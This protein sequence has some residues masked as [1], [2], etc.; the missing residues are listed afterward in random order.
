M[1]NFF[2][3]LWKI[4]EDRHGCCPVHRWQRVPSQNPFFHL[5]SP[6]ECREQDCSHS[7]IPC[8]VSLVVLH[9]PPLAG[10]EIQI[11]RG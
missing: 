1:G 9:W 5:H 3:N 4:Q 6:V 11:F 2:L 10:S 7:L 8:S